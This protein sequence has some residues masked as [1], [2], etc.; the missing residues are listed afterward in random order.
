M[1]ES[2]RFFSPAPGTLSCQEAFAQLGA[3]GDPAMSASQQATCQSIA[4]FMAKH[5]FLGRVIEHTLAYKYENIT[6]KTLS[7]TINWLDI[8]KQIIS[9]M[10]TWLPVIMQIIAAFGL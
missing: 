8:I 1:S 4:T 7:G 10:P 2:T 9:D 6:G 5:K 3:V